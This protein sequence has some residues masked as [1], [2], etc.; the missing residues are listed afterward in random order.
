MQ[1]V[2]DRFLS[3]FLLQMAVFSA[4]DATERA[5]GASSI[6]VH[7]AIEFEN[8]KDPVRLQN[9]YAGD[10][11]SAMQA[12]TSTA[13]PLAYLMQAGFD[14]LEGQAHFARSSNRSTPKSS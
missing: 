11:G 5:T 13:V 3:P 4:I 8:R 10:G 7:G 14:Q 12:A 6:V 9:I 1:M 2:N